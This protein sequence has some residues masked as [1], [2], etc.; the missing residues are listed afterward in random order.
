MIGG[1]LLQ[2]D[3]NRQSITLNQSILEK[4]SS[5]DLIIAPELKAITYIQKVSKKSDLYSFGMTVLLSLL[6]DNQKVKN[7]Q[8]LAKEMVKYKFNPN[9]L[10]VQLFDAMEKEFQKQLLLIVNQIKGDFKED[11]QK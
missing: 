2:N 11:F 6:K 3:Q 4:V 1:S 10:N 5:T 7:L 8:E 9:Y